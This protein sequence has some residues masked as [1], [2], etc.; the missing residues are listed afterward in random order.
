M[1]LTPREQDP[2]PKPKPV[3]AAQRPKAPA[4]P[5]PQPDRTPIAADPVPPPK[6]KLPGTG[7]SKSEVQATPGS[8]TGSKS[9]SGPSRAGP[10]AQEAT[11]A[12]SLPGASPTRRSVPGLRVYL[13][14]LPLL[15]VLGIIIYIVTDTGTVKVTGTDPNLVVRIDGGRGIRIENLGEPL[16]LRTGPHDLEVKRG[17]LIVKTQ[18]FQ[19]QRGRE[20]PL[21]VTYIPKPPPTEPGS[22]QE[23]EPPSPSVASE[24]KPITSTIHVE[25]PKPAPPSPKAESLGMKLTLIPAGTF[26]MGSTD[27]EKDA[28][29]NEKPQHEVRITRPFYLGVHEVTQGQYQAVMGQNPSQFKGS[30]DLPVETV[31]WLDAVK[32]CNKLSEREGR[33]PY[34][35]IDGG[36]VTIAGGEGYRLPTE[37]EWEY[38][39][40]AGTTTRYSFGDDE[41]ALGQYAWYHTNSGIQ[42]HPVGKKQPNA[43]G[44]YDMQGNVWEWC[45]DGYDG[46]YYKRSPADDPRGF[47]LAANRVF[48]GG[49]W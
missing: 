30:D 2:S 36:A 37:A 35:H 18:K 21:K 4:A 43:F 28:E 25:S 39:C 20:T 7:G 3:D 19:I 11:V 5:K 32:F 34:Y 10:R 42:T 14:V 33:K 22:N 24:F 8:A 6:G 49:S 38:A 13:T 40:R 17:D 23:A 29:S 41:N 9:A 45:W 12:S 47:E 26:Q 15:A 27:A 31:S 16:T 48:R 44:L 46:D 1:I